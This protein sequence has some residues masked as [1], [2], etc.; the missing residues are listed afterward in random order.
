MA[1]KQWAKFPSF[2]E[3]ANAHERFQAKSPANMQWARALSIPLLKGASGSVPTAADV[4]ETLHAH[5]PAF[6]QFLDAMIGSR[7]KLA[8]ITEEMLH[9]LTQ[10]CTH[11]T[12][13]SRWDWTPAKIREQEAYQDPVM[14]TARRTAMRD[15]LAAK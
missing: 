7:D 6:Q 15:C 5:Q 13:E 12:L 11:M 4:W 3:Y 2:L 8:L 10:H 9:T 14:A 1:S